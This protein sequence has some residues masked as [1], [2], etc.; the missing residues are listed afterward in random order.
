[1]LT[2]A[3]KEPIAVVGSA[4]RL[5]GNIKNPSELW[6]LLQ[7]PQDVQSEVP[8]DRF[9]VDAFYHAD[10]PRKGRSNARHGYFLQESLRHFDA[11]FF[12]IQAGEAESIDPQQRLLLETTYDA[13]SAAGFS[14][15]EL[16][17]SNTAVYV[18]IMT[19]DFEV[20]RTI[21]MEHNPTYLATGAA[22][23]IASNRLSYFFDWH[24]PSVS[25]SLFS[26]HWKEF[27]SS[28]G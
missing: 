19:H 24:G 22:T 15:E 20:T 4:C 18:G 3:V 13:L 5:P 17:G 28:T 2:M 21:D 1:M 14:L 23:S 25:A 12:K 16:R 27:H 9:N 11:S 7:Q 6:A 10:G 8:K 26:A